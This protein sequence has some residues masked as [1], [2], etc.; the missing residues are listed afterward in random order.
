M[1]QKCAQS[2]GIGKDFCRN[3]LPSWFKQN[4]PAKE[5][6]DILRKLSERNVNTVCVSAKCPNLGSCFGHNEL[7]FMILGDTCTRNCLFCAVKKSRTQDLGVDAGEAKRVA[8]VVKEFGLKYVVITSVTRDDL[9]DGGAS[10]FVEVVEEIRQTS[11]HTK[12]EVLIPDFQGRFLSLRL[13]ADVFPDI[14]AHNIE[15]VR[16]VSALIRPLADYERS[17]K[18]LDSV[19]KIVPRTVTKSS[20]MLGLGETHEEIVEALKDLRTVNCDIVTLGQYLAPSLKHYPVQEFIPVEKF[21]VYQDVAYTLG[22]KAVLSGPLV[23]SSYQA[24]RLY[25][26]I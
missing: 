21:A 17:L 26:Q 13:L 22:F 24:Q 11:R 25:E 7:T 15:T 23:R 8:Y 14:I 1:D 19:K 3:R 20:L 5:S 10:R 12:I 16:R 18:V 6:F 2:E 4:I 9:E